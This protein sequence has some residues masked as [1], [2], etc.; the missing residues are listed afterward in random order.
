MRPDD[1]SGRARESW[2]ADAV[3]GAYSVSKLALNGMFTL[4]QQ[5]DCHTT[6]MVV[7]AFLKDPSEF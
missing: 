4:D 3:A 2:A 5:G 1:R 7:L 6:S